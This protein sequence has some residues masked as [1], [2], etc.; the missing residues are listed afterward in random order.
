MVYGT[1]MR[2]QRNHWRLFGSKYITKAVVKG[3][4]FQFRG[5]GMD[6][7]L[8]RR[9]SEHIVHGEIYEVS[10]GVLDLQDWY[11]LL[12]KRTKIL[13]YHWGQDGSGTA[14]M[15]APLSCWV[16][17]GLD[18]LPYSWAR[19]LPHGRWPGVAT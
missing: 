16:Y 2:N 13:A 5:P 7:P 19:K 17:E 12:Y 18:R 1:L 6:F 15:V 8:L 11:E 9:D 14:G 3:Q 10:R 4:L